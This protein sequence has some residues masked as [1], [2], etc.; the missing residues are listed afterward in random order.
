L[1]D[2]IDL[3][4]GMPDLIAE[5]RGGLGLLRL[6]RPQALN[7][8]TIGMIHEMTATLDSWDSDPEVAAAV[9]VGEGEKAFCAGG[10]VRAL[11]DARFDPDST[12]RA[13]FYRDEYRLNRQ[14]FRY[15]KPYVAIMDGV[16]MGGGVGV[17]V[18]GSHRVVTERTL[19]AMPETGIGLF[20]DV[21]GGYF[22]P[23]CPGA[24]G[25]YLGLTGVRLLAADCVYAG[26]ATHYVPADRVKDLVDALG[27]VTDAGDVDRVLDRFAAD[28]GAAALAE[29]RHEI[30]RHFS[31][32]S[33]AAIQESLAAAGDDWASRAL[34]ILAKKSPI[35]LCVTYRQLREGRALD[36]ED[37]MVMEYR[38]SQ[39]AMADT[40]FYE[41]V[42]AVIIDKDNAPRWHHAS[43]AD[44]TEQEVAA[45]FAPLGDNDLTFD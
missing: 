28:P 34:S 40:D 37:V 7:A 14:I 20:P 3:A 41:G 25:M 21:G 38:L 13:D 8:L 5:R 16:T 35:S 36:F 1:N 12:Y 4:A 39:R 22:L 9:I 11:Y 26:I 15:A 10:D 19:F 33:V 44:V 24:L 45:Y 27:S 17:S 2:E 18:H 29:P 31:A 6:N 43:V 23:R 42:R 32:D 30:D